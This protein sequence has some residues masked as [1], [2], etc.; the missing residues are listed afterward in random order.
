[1][2]SCLIFNVLFFLNLKRNILFVNSGK[3]KFINKSSTFYKDLLYLVPFF[4][5]IHIN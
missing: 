4:Y 1:M 3:I 2:P 5:N